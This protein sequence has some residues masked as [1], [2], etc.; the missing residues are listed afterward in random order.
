MVWETKG[1]INLGKVTLCVCVC[2]C[3]CEDKLHKRWWETNFIY[4]SDHF[5]T[6]VCHVH[7]YIYI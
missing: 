3:V 4:R 6:H 5:F 2:V 1:A 7:V